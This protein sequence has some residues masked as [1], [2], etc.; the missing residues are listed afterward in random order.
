MLPSA[1]QT[2]IAELATILIEGLQP[3]GRLS[4][5]LEIPGPAEIAS[6]ITPDLIFDVDAKESR[7]LR[8]A[9][10][11]F[12]LV[13]LSFRAAVVAV[14]YF[15]ERVIIPSNDRP[16]WIDRTRIRELAG[17]EG[18]FWLEILELS[19]G[20]FR[21]R[22]KGIIDN[23]KKRSRI[24]AIAGLAALVIGV[25]VPPVM[26]VA[27]PALMVAPLV[28]AAL[29]DRP[30]EAM[31]SIYRAWQEAHRAPTASERQQ[32]LQT[33]AI[34]SGMHRFTEQVTEVATEAAQA[35]LSSISGDEIRGTKVKITVEVT[36][37]G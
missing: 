24:I 30:I 28:T 26:A 21:S 22:L 18:E 14:A 35:A 37:G 25:F 3:E 5:F 34:N 15:D 1:T 7:Q 4:S 17:E 27:V 36:V 6:G 12:G 31:T 8:D 33:T 20:S 11:T 16:E 2:D 9:L 32:R 19:S 13:D 29:P 10:A 23:P